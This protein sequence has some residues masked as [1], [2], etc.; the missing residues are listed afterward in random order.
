MED[1]EVHGWSDFKGET[2]QS[3]GNRQMSD[4]SDINK[5]QVCDVLVFTE[6][7]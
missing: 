2:D 1:D 3:R 7:L 4:T 5:I 6:Y